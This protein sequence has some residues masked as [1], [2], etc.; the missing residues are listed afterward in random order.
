[1]TRSALRQQFELVHSEAL[2]AIAS[3]RP[4]R[5]GRI[6]DMYEEALLAFPIAWQEY[7]EKFDTQAVSGLELWDLGPL[8]GITR[9]LFHEANAALASANLEVANRLV[10]LPASVATK[11]AA[12]G[13]DGLVEKMLG[14]YPIYYQQAH[15]AG[16]GPAAEAIE[17]GSLES[18]NSFLQY[19]AVPLL[20]ESGLGQRA[21]ELASTATNNLL[22]AA[23]DE[24]DAV[25]VREVDE[26]WTH[27]LRRSHAGDSALG[28]TIETYRFGLAWWAV[29]R[30][31]NTRD[32]DAGNGLAQIV[33]HLVSRFSSLEQLSR[34][35]E[36]ALAAETH[37]GAPWST[38]IL[39]ELSPHEA[40]AIAP[41]VEL[42]H[43]WAVLA[44]LKGPVQPPTKLSPRP[45]LD[46]RLETAVAALRDVQ[47][48]TDL[49]DKLPRPENLHEVVSS[50]VR[51][52]EVA[53]DER[54]EALAARTR[55]DDLDATRI[56][57]FATAVRS[58]WQEQRVAPALFSMAR[59][60]DEHGEPQPERPGSFFGR[61]DWLPKEWFISGAEISLEGF[62]Q[63]FGRGVSQSELDAVLGL[64]RDA[65][66]PPAVAK[67]GSL[68]ETTATA[69]EELRSNGYNP[70]VIL[71]PATW[72][73]SGTTGLRD[74]QDLDLDRAEQLPDPIRRWFLGTLKNVPL[75][76]PAADLG[77]LM[78]VDFHAVGRWQQWPG[79]EGEQLRVKFETF[80]AEEAAE[81]V[82]E[83]PGLF[84]E[85]G[86]TE[87]QVAKVRER[88]LVEI[89]EYFDFEVADRRAIQM[90]DLATAS[91]EA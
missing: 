83:Q 56:G 74:L 23:I 87:R 88:V 81:L 55:E 47:E 89:A 11:A 1:M 4:D 85:E 14:L 43:G 33:Q 48:A 64:I 61:R 84:A 20:D 26:G 44:V 45:W 12:I 57:E 60:Y 21:A 86:S 59:T 90:I 71:V 78:I 18:V 15:R 9:N 17:Q 40:H 52:L 66:H 37:R 31:R 10:H 29:R 25:A 67:E 30:L 7:G 28:K 68:L 38:W 6:A 16:V 77:V 2:A 69:I 70:T 49:W 50:I 80:T 62:A 27:A 73:Y 63:D 91:P 35:L 72:Q 65:G 41:D 34:V 3:D 51:A 46:S 54:K 42:I 32:K 39:M 82:Q 76:A 79:D 22:K 75:V 13:A 24:A 58:G 19:G 53:A 5:Y 8:E 36:A